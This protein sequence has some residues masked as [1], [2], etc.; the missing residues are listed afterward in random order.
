MVVV[1]TLA[2][3]GAVAAVDT[4]AVDG[5]EVAVDTV[6]VECIPVEAE[7]TSAVAWPTAVAVVITINLAN[8]KE[9]K[10]SFTGEN[11]ENRVLPRGW[12]VVFS[13]LNFGPWTLP[14][15]L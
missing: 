1:G 4:A 13:A 8:C 15:R 12:H 9:R 5:T 2:A 6:V 11:G 3:D 14:L 7:R 10:I